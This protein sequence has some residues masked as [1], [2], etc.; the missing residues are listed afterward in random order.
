MFK[1]VEEKKK[2]EGEKIRLIVIP[3][4]I[5]PPV[6]LVI[7]Q[8]FMLTNSALDCILSNLQPIFTYKNTNSSFAMYIVI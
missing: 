1:W 4:L 6:I 5:V 2:N 3:I 8:S 7:T